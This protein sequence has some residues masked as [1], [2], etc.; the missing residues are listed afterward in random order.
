MGCR[1]RFLLLDNVLPLEYTQL[2]FISLNGNFCFK[3]DYLI[4]SDD[5]VECRV[6]MTAFA[7]NGVFGVVSATGKNF[8]F[9]ASNR[10]AVVGHGSTTGTNANCI[11]LSGREYIC[12][13]SALYIGNTLN[14]APFSQAAFKSEQPIYIGAVNNGGTASAPLNGAIYYFK[15]LSA[16][17]ELLRSFVP[18]TRNGD[19]EEGLFE[20]VY[21]RF[22]PK[23]P[24]GGGQS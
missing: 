20:L 12:D 14:I 19:G 21:Q 16:K 18:C 17:G 2:G 11:F 24:T 23:L 10:D 4:N 9:L 3:T 8:Y 5:R 13:K 15:I 22:Y 6:R 1:R 7:Q